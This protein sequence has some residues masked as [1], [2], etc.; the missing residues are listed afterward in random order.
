[1]A[2][3]RDELAQAAIVQLVK[4]L[5]EGDLESVR[6][7]LTED[8]VL[9][10]PSMGTK[11]IGRHAFTR[12]RQ[13]RPAAWTDVEVDV[14]NLIACGEH[15]TVEAIVTGTHSGD[16]ITGSHSFGTLAATGRRAAR[17][18]CYVCTVHEGRIAS[19]TA[20]YDR[21]ALI[22]ELVR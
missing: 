4:A 1:M 9:Q 12:R 15:Y 17:P 10:I 11:L 6:H 16:W 14:V 19:L 8:A 21:I 22:S 7:L 18:A 3:E 20:Y 2:A 13:R 5:N